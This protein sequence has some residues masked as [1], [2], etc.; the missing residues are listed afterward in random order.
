MRVSRP[1]AQAATRSSQGPGIAGEGSGPDDCRPDEEAPGA[2]GRDDG[3]DVE[4]WAAPVEEGPESGTAEDGD[5]ELE[6]MGRGEGVAGS[7]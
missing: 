4:E 6:D 7:G 1:A 2:G 5:G 3:A